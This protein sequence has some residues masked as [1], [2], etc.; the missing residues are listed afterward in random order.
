MYDRNYEYFTTIAKELNISRAAEKLFISQPSLSKFLIQLEEKLGTPLFIRG[1]NTMTL[2]PAGILYLNY[3]QDAQRL[4]E[5]FQKELK[6][7]T[8][9][10]EER[11]SFG[12]TPGIAALISYALPDAFGKRC[13]QVKLE[14]TED[15][16]LQLLSLFRHNRIDMVLSMAGSLQDYNDKVVGCA[17]VLSERILLVAPKSMP[18]VQKLC[19]LDNS[20]QNPCPIPEPF[21]KC[22]HIITGKSNHILYQK[23]RRI[24]DAYA[25]EPLSVVETYNID[26]CLRMVDAG[27]GIAF[28]SQMYIENGP[29][30]SNTAFF[31]VDSELFDCTRVIY[32]HADAFTDSQRALIEVVR[33]VCG[34][35]SS[36]PDK[37]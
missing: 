27:H 18:Q 7:L 31:S 33:Q 30:L 2:T 22:C 5:D 13:P 16:G 37:P 14:L 15:Y 8:S 19:P 4:Q 34:Q 26:N 21:L 35:I 20:L 23:T 11:L 6:K 10:Q 29:P 28:I 3:I 12:I 25:L 36:G 1:K 24:I 9:A 17:P 32:Y